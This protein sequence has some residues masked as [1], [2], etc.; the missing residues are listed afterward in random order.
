MTGMRQAQWVS[1]KNTAFS[2]AKIVLLVAV[3]TAIPRSGIFV[4]WIVPVLILI[5]PMSLFISLRLIPKH[6]GHAGGEPLDA[7]RMARFASGNYVGSLFMLASTLALPIIVT[8]DAGTRAAAYFFVPWTIAASLQLIAL[9]MTTSLTVE[10]AFDEAKLREYSRRVLLQTA[11]LVLPLA[12]ILLLGAPYVLRAFG[13]PYASEGASLL[14]LLAVASIPNILVFLGLS[15]ARITHNGRMML[16]V[17]GALCVSTLGLSL[18]LLPRFGIE[19]VGVAALVSQLA[20]ATWL[21]LGILRPV[22]LGSAR[23]MLPP[24]RAVQGHDS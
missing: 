5:L 20:V 6:V 13:A 18:L 14:R 8:N 2:A 7:R 24:D 16:Y 11:R 17:Q 19:G 15:I 12:L 3:A 22:L 21:M 4:A 23:P 10:V 9:Y 1:I